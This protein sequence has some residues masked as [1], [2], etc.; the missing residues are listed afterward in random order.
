VPCIWL[1]HRREDLYPEPHAFRP[2]RFLDTAPGAY[3]WVPFG[4]GTRRCL[5]ASFA[6]LEMTEILGALARGPQLAPPRGRTRPSP[7]AAAPSP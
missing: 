6:M 5:G 7:S 4:G 2:E 3:S 1:L